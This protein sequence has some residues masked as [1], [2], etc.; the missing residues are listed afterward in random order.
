MGNFDGFQTKTCEYIKNKF[1]DKIS[2]SISNV[3]YSH[4]VRIGGKGPCTGGILWGKR[5]ASSTPPHI[6]YR[7]AN[8]SS[9]KRDTYLQREKDGRKIMKVKL[10]TIYR[11]YP[12]EK[13]VE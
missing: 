6:K 4:M 5:A 13:S 3:Y 11:S 8:F 9:Y 1:Q 2:P 10:I 12:K 7:S